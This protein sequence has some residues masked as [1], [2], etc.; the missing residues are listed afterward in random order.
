V[1]WRG[2]QHK[3]HDRSQLPCGLAN[4]GVRFIQLKFEK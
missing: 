3:D 2:F 4:K 1:A